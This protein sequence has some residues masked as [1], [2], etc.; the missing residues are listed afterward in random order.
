MKKFYK[1]YLMIICLMLLSTL[2]TKVN[3]QHFNFVGGD[4]SAN[5]WTIQHFN[6]VGGDPS[7]NL[8]TI[9]IGGA[10][11][12][13]VNL[14]AGDEIAVF[15]GDLIVGVITLTQVCTPDNQFENFLV[16]FTE[17]V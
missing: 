8:W 7:A 14:E 5:L 11:L 4:P 17:L 9:Y 10:S 12:N 2:S 1:N 3:A 6:F 16:A 13:G 15:D